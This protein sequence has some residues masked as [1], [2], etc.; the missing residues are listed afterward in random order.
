MP[1]ERREELLLVDII[2]QADAILRA[3]D[4]LDEEGMRASE[5]HRSAVL[6]SLCLIGE[7]SNRMPP[8]LTDAHP[9]IPWARM[10]GF[11]NVV[12]HTYEHIDAAIVWSTVEQVRS[13]RLQVLAIL[14]SD[15]PLVAEA[16]RQRR[17]AG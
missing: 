10:V 5:L 13:V 9:E 11:R 8:D 2:E 14:E 3:V 12:L 15:H 1:P 16:L 17:D 6:W 4:G 7:A